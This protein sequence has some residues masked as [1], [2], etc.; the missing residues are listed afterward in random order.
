MTT[1]K[2]PPEFGDDGRLT[3]RCIASFLSEIE[4]AHKPR[5]AAIER[6]LRAMDRDCSISLSW[7]FDFN[8]K[9]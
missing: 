3:E 4:A 9:E 8:M 7:R 5:I 2:T 6:S 1:L